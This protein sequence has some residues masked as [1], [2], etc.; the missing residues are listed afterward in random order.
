MKDTIYILFDGYDNE[1]SSVWVF[2]NGIT[3]EEL[4]N[5]IERIT[6]WWNNQD[7]PDDLTSYVHKRFKK[8]G[9]KK[10][11]HVIVSY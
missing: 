1:V 6:E 9:G 2:K 11:D 10:L 7:S 8:L 4:D 3:K 5:H